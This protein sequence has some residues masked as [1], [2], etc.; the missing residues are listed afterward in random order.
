MGSGKQKP[1]DTPVDIKAAVRN[2]MQFV[3]DLYEG[4][5]LQDLALEEVRLSD[6]EQ[7]WLVTVGF[8]SLGG[9]HEV[10]TSSGLFP[11]LS[12][13]TRLERLPRDLKLVKVNARTGMPAPDLSDRDLSKAG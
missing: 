4:V 9:Y 6:D 10:R 2:A 11:T 13:H 5:N 8:R 1:A 12:Q 7:W 3:R